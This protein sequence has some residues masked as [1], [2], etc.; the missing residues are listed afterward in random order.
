MARL[1][2]Y[3]LGALLLAGAGL[4]LPAHAR[5]QQ[6]GATIQSDGNC[7]STNPLSPGV[8]RNVYETNNG[9]ICMFILNGSGSPV[10]STITGPLGSKVSAQSVS[11]V[12]ASDQSLIPISG[13]ITLGPGSSLVGKVGIDQTTPGT[14]NLVQQ[15]YGVPTAISISSATTTQLIALTSAKSIIITGGFVQVA[16]ANNITLEYGTGSSCGT[17]TTNITGAVN[18]LTSGGFQIPAMVLPAGQALCILTTTTAQVSGVVSA[19]AA[20]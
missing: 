6:I 17:G 1:H 20:Q 11:V 19:L 4:S 3:A 14:T 5:A 10:S 12:I 8:N 2:S 15:A 18:L 16:G 13:T 9:A 7:P